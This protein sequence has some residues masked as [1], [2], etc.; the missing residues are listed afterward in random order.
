MAKALQL[1]PASLSDV[2]HCTPRWIPNRNETPRRTINEVSAS[3][4]IC[5]NFADIAPVLK[6][7]CYAMQRCMHLVAQRRNSAGSDRQAHKR[8]G[9][10]ESQRTLG[11]FAPDS[12]AR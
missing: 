7:H 9:A 10:R 2:I 11:L 12:G 8:V 6:L 1:S 5:R 4:N 3:R